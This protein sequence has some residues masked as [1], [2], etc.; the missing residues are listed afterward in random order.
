MGNSVGRYIYFTSKWYEYYFPNS[1]KLA[2]HKK[3]IKPEIRILNKPLT[4]DDVIFVDLTDDIGLTLE[5]EGYSSKFINEVYEILEYIK[6]KYP[7]YIN[8]KGICI[9]D[10]SFDIKVM[11]S[12]NNDNDVMLCVPCNVVERTLY[13][14]NNNF[15]AQVK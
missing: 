2:R 5:F 9:F 12:C 6:D 7:S 14:V 3:L 15:T 13:L 8:V 1:D 4:I 11:I 10:A